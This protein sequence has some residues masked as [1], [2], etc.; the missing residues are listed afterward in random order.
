MTKAEMIREYKKC[1]SSHWYC[2]T[3]YGKTLDKDTGEVKPFATFSG[4]Y[5]KIEYR[6]CIRDFLQ[7]IHERVMAKRRIDKPDI[8]DEKS[9]QMYVTN[10]VMA[11]CTWAILFLDYFRGLITHEKESKM[12]SKTDFNT[13]FGMIDFM[14]E[15]N[16]DFLKPKPTDLMRSHM[17][18]GLKSRNSLIIGDAGVRPGAGGGFDLIYNTEFAHQTNTHQKLAAE[19]EACKGVN[20]LDSTPN[21]KHNAHAVTC[22]FAE[23]HPKESSFL[24]V[25]IHW[26]KRRIPEWYDIKKRDY[27]GDEAQIAQELDMSREGSV[28]GRAFKLFKPNHIVDVP[29]DFKPAFAIAGFDFGWV[30][31]TACV[32]IVPWANDTWVIIDEYADHEKPVHVHAE[33]VHEKL[34][35]WGLTKVYWIADPS[36][37]SRSREVGKSFYEIYNSE[38][39]PIENRIKFEQGDNAVTEGIANINTMF[40]KD[41]LLVNK[42]CVTL[43]DAL[44]EAKYPTNKNGEPTGDK[45]EEAWYTDILDALRYGVSRIAKYQKVAEGRQFKT[46]YPQP[47]PRGLGMGS[48]GRR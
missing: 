42:K 48:Y 6:D 45:Y 7:L 2:L 4:Q 33:K 46:V 20:I 9:R 12:D 23:K 8:C 37:E 1:K 43:I 21:G 39:V 31:D 26:S 14:L 38:S 10:S 19:R 3:T 11:Y 47:R 25:P 40:W 27:N 24:Y 36:G 17:N 5:D 29:I 16:P 13:P 44:N 41:K 18:I 15:H 28:T 35:R 22:E 32:L 34:R 30:H